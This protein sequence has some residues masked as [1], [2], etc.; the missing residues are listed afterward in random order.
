MNSGSPIKEIVDM[1]HSKGEERCASR[2]KS[3]HL[4][5]TTEQLKDR[6]DLVAI[7]GVLYDLDAIAPRHPGG[8]VIRASGAYDASALFHSM[9]PGKDTKSSELL[10]QNIVGTHLLKPGIDPVY[11][12][13]SPFAVDL[14]RSVRK[15]MRSLL[16]ISWYAPR[17]FWIRILVIAMFTLFFECNW[18]FTGHWMW[19][20]LCGCMH[21]QIG[22]SIQHDASHGALSRNPR[23]NAFFAYGADW[24][25][26]SRWIW[27][28]QHILWHHPHTNH[29]TL[30]PDARSAEPFLVF[31]DY[32]KKGPA[33]PPR[34]FEW[35]KCQDLVTHA[36][37]SLYGVSVVFNPYVASM[38]HNEHIPKSITESGGFMSNQKLTA[39]CWRLFYVARMILL[40]WWNGASLLC[41][42]ILVH[43]WVP[44]SESEVGSAKLLNRQVHV[45]GGWFMF[46]SESFDEDENFVAARAAVEKE[47]RRVRDMIDQVGEE[48]FEMIQEQ[49]KQHNKKTMEIKEVHSPDGGKERDAVHVADEGLGHVGDSPWWLAVR[50]AYWRRPE[51]P[52]SSIKGRGD[53]PVTHISFND[54]KA[55]CK[56]AGRRLPTEREWE[57]AARGGADDASE[58][59]ISSCN[60]WQGSFPKENDILDGFDGV[61]PVDAFEANG[62]G[63]YQMVGNV[64]E[65][66]EGGKDMDSN[67]QVMRGGSFVDS[68]DGTINHLLRP[69]TRMENSPD[70]A[71]SNTGF[72]CASSEILPKGEL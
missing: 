27:F 68:V 15:E 35:A 31:S 2:D 52:D 40:P 20:I 66:V 48:T 26:N 43:T 8:E 70:S 36:V 9:H 44:M 69:S 42:S 22:L 5:L 11:M 28:Q 33:R 1:E 62:F 54:A 32:S 49:L 46:G 50:G 71:A 53:D 4:S 17:S 51:G 64:W 30:D 63:L 41:A 59:D 67:S 12:Y 3:E 37:L 57:Y 16:A 29:Q 19:G 34:V 24:I 56:W 58:M 14:L 13:N 72:R 60:G 45:S 39:W 55:Y 6:P 47:N 38:R 65:W 23:V 7:D 61:A 10:C 18:M 21:A 25:G